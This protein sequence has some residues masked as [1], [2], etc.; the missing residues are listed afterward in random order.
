MNPDG[1]F[2]QLREKWELT[3]ELQLME[4]LIHRKKFPL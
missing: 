3:I 1:L 4:N 2:L